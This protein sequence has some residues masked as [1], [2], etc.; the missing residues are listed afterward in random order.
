[1]GEIT[2]MKGKEGEI[3]IFN[4]N[5]V[6]EAYVYK[7]SQNSWQMMGEVLGT[8]NDKKYYEVFN[9]IDFREIR[10]FQLENTIL[11]LMLKWMGET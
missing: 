3:R 11:Y 1:M 7:A 8:K 6:A 5:G 10:L 4:N 2:K 9:L